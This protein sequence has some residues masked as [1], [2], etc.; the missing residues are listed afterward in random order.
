MLKYL[1]N[2]LGYCKR[3][4]SRAAWGGTDSDL[5]VLKK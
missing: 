5:G 3:G 1:V 2:P 4:T